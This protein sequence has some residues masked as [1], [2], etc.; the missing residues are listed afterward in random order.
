MSSLLAYPCG[1][2]LSVIVALVAVDDV[3]TAVANGVL[4]ADG[5][6]ERRRGDARD[7]K[8]CC[9]DAHT[10]FFG[11]CSAPVMLPLRFVTLPLA[12]LRLAFRLPFSRSIYLSFTSRIRCEWL[13]IARDTTTTARLLTAKR[14]CCKRIF[15]GQRI[16]ALVAPNND[17][18]NDTAMKDDD[19]NDEDDEYED[20]DD[21]D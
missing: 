6:G 3:V 11:I 1:A 12:E 18:D 13:I 14:R 5:S 17:D 2:V 10:T 9:H 8:G 19:N 4:V 7:V 16:P 20:D 21:D 15:A